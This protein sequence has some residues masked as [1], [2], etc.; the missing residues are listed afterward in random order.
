MIIAETGQFFTC[1]L[2]KDPMPIINA[3][4]IKIGRRNWKKIKDKSIWNEIGIRKLP[5]N[6]EPASIIIDKKIIPKIEIIVSN[7]VKNMTT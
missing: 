2:K 5:G 7:W 1:C 3:G 6:C 4:N